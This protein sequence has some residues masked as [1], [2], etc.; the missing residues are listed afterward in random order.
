M[1]KKHNHNEIKKEFD[2]LILKIVKTRTFNCSDEI[3]KLIRE[4]SPQIEKI[5]NILGASKQ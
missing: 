5:H 1:S 4:I 3:E 2:N